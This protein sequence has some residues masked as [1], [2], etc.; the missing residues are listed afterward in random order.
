MSEEVVD[1]KRYADGG[2]DEA[3]PRRVR[4][5]A[6]RME[7]TKKDFPLECR[8]ILSAHGIELGR[9]HKERKNGG[10]VNATVVGYCR[11]PDCIRVL[12]DG[13]KVDMAWHCVFWERIP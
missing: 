9:F 8:V 3:T 4:T 7:Q 12:V 11:E 1:L 2:P 13:R 5:N 6:E 10:V